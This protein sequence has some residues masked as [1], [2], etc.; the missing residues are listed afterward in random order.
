MLLLDVLI[1][2]FARA[3]ADAGLAGQLRGCAGETYHRN[4]RKSAPETTWEQNMEL[5]LSFL[6]AP[7]KRIWK[8][9]LNK[10]ARE[11]AADPAGRGR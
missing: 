4:C 10:A 5:M 8:K 1:D 6:E 2:S 9:D 11:A 3:G 7:R